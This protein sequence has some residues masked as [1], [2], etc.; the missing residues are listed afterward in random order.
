MNE[1]GRRIH[2]PTAWVMDTPQHAGGYSAGDQ[3][4]EGLP[5][6]GRQETRAQ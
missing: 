2:G 6:R 3:K 4:E 5:T 1:S